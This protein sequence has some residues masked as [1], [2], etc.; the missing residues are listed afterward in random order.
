MIKRNDRINWDQRSIGHQ[1][2]QQ[3]YVE[4]LQENATEMGLT[5]DKLLVPTFPKKPPWLT[6][7]VPVNLE[8]SQLKKSTKNPIIFLRKIQGIM[9]RNMN[10]TDFIYTV[11]SVQNGKSACA[12][13]PPTTQA[14]TMPRYRPFSEQL[15]K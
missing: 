10:N 14:Y 4:E 2:Y 15:K 7:S 12:F 8:L 6:P 9:H 13:K 1:K 11:G 3:S 5:I